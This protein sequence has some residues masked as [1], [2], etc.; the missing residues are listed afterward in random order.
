MNL[1]IL[2]MTEAGEQRAP[3]YE[4]N[5]KILVRAKDA[6]QARKLAAS[7]AMDEPMDTWLKRDWSRVQRLGWSA[8]QGPARVLMVDSNAS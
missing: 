6:Q 2:T 1:Y 3:N 7:V 5:D 4:V 8:R